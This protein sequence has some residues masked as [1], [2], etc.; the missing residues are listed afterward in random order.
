MT[1]VQYKLN[2]LS[3]GNLKTNNTSAVGMPRINTT[4]PSVALKLIFQLSHQIRH[5]LVPFWLNFIAIKIK[6]L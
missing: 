4:M 5:K 2:I 3:F 6:F 1:A